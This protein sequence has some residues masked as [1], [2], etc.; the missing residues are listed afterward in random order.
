M[1]DS[2]TPAANQTSP[3]PS[4]TASHATD[5]GLVSL[6]TLWDES[7]WHEYRYRAANPYS[8]ED[9]Y[10]DED[11]Y[12]RDVHDKWVQEQKENERFEKLTQDWSQSDRGSHVEFA[13]SE[14]VP[15]KEGEWTRTSVS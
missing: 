8:L 9:F 5:Q 6:Q 14:G 4:P 2:Q 11:D 12:E 15:L 1:A 10:N 7:D 3:P 13:A